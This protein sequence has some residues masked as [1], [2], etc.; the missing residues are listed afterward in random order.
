MDG[1]RAKII[2]K[3]R[4]RNSSADSH[5]TN[6]RAVSYNVAVPLQAALEA[7]AD[8]EASGEK[9][10]LIGSKVVMPE[11]AVGQKMQRRDRRKKS[12]A[13]T[14]GTAGRNNILKLGHLFDEDE[15]ED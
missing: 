8:G 9:P 10:V 2:F 5:E 14:T 7:D 4:K 13:Q 12:G 11:Y 3:Q 6:S 1:G 15:D